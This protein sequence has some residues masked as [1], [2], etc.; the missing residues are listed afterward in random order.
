MG[1]PGLIADSGWFQLALAGT[2]ILVGAI[3]MR[4]TGMGFAL[5][6]APF[7]VMAL[8]P[9]EGVLVT[10][11]CS[12]IA[13]LLNL[14][15]IHADIDWRRAAS[16]VPAGLL[17]TIPG[18]LLVLLIPSA[19]LLIAVSVVVIA[20][21][22]FTVLSRSMEVPNSMWIGA[23]GGLSSGFTNVTAGIAAP[24][25]VIYALATR[26]EHRSFA[27]TVQVHFIVL[28]VAALVSKAALPSLPPLGWVVMIGLLVIGLVGGNILARWVNGAK[29]MRWIIVIALAGALG[30]LIQGLVQ[31]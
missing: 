12:V 10:N 14:T 7:L 1:D 6:S 2:A 24:G 11:V 28:G 17:G 9:F 27:A 25:L 23:A 21:L 30:S 18:A 31:L 20:A 22:L 26:W 19:A 15:Q 29:A 16:M 4:A 3:A 13:A 8:G 5:L